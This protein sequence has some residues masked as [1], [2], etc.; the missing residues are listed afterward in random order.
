ML[1]GKGGGVSE[2]RCSAPG[3]MAVHDSLPAYRRP[4]AA[5]VLRAQV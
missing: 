1:P 3:G 2:N 5:A 4:N